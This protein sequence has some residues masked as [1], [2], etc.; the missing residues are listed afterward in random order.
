MVEEKTHY[1]SIL[2]NTSI[3]GGTQAIQ[4]LSTVIRGKF[5]AIFLGSVGMGINTIFQSVI[6]II[7]PLSS[8]G[9]SF[10]AV[11]D[12]SQAKERPEEN[13]ISKIVTV[14]KK[15][16]LISSIF[17]ALLIIIFSKYISKLTFNVTDYTFDFILLSIAIFFYI[18]TIT[19][20]CILQGYRHLSSIAKVSL[21]NSLLSLIIAIPIY[22]FWKIKGISSAIIINSI[23][24][25]LTTLYFSKKIKIEPVKLSFKEIF[26]T[27][28][29][30]AKLG[31]VLTITSFIGTL[32]NYLINA[33]ISNFGS[34]SDIGLYSAGI[35][36]T[37][38][39]I[40]MIFTAIAVDFFPRLSAVCNDNIKVNKMVNEQTEII[41]IIVSPLLIII[42]VTAPLL[43]RILLS[44]EFLVIRDFICWI[45][46]GTFF[47][48]I[49]YPMGHIPY[50]KGDK[51]IFFYLSILTNILN[52]FFSI[53]G[54]K[55]GGLS[56]I[57]ISFL[58]FNIFIFILH[59]IIIKRKYSF[60]IEKIAYRM[61]CILFI[62]VFITFLVSQIF[63]NTYGYI[64]QCIMLSVTLFYSYKELEKRVN[65]KDI[66]LS[67]IYSF[68]NK[69]T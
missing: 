51:K 63:N 62:L 10:S 30:M 69:K 59:Y 35:S 49:F 25:Y 12:I 5:I 31:I 9:M 21:I 22:Y 50:A 42:M 54:Y 38:Q 7:I 23:I 8:L 2:K 40:G 52:L 58:V 17:G 4:V 41:M 20:S 24:I 16:V 45:S 15:W 60:Y 56:G 64:I 32:T 29:T 19:H 57:A 39:Y 37:N 1:K 18:L 28:S 27:G 67:K 65:I 43:I 44:D 68:R 34:I 14:L 46:F 33:Y 53:I 3:F 6:N 66:I 55:L 36:I 11:R 26:N 48:S 47:K 13:N 61:F